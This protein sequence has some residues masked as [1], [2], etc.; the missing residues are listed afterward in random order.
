MATFPILTATFY[1]FWRFEF[2]EEKLNRDLQDKPFAGKYREML[3]QLFCFVFILFHGLTVKRY[4]C[5]TRWD[6]PLERERF[7]K[8]A[9][10][11][12]GWKSV[13]YKITRLTEVSQSSRRKQ[14]HVDINQPL[15]DSRPGFKD[16]WMQL[17]E[18]QHS[19][20][21]KLSPNDGFI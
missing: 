4:A 19:C 11:N 10:Y 17:K 5:E 16:E 6:P 8:S 1:G 14:T 18:F 3:P 7:P 2:C 21:P 20:Q 15:F 9:A 12:P 13:N